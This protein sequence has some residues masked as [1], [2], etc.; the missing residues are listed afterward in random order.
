MPAP[1]IEPGMRV[2]CRHERLYCACGSCVVTADETLTVR[3]R[4]YFPGIGAMLA[5]AEH[6]ND[7]HEPWFLASGFKPRHDG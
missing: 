6:Q 1:V 5:F 4:R 3:E 7:D 2:R